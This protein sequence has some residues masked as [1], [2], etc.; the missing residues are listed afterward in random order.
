VQRSV[1][2]K[3]WWSFVQDL[4]AWGW[5]FAPLANDVSKEE[6]Q[7]WVNR[8]QWKW[9]ENRHSFFACLLFRF[10]G[11]FDAVE[12]PPNDPKVF[13]LWITMNVRPVLQVLALEF[14]ITSYPKEHWCQRGIPEPLMEWKLP[15]DKPALGLLCGG[16]TPVWFPAT[17][18]R[19]DPTEPGAFD[20]IEVIDN[21]LPV[22]LPN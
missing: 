18:S 6:I 11:K 12:I 9:R 10:C 15:C 3:L 5:S 21:M 22:Q 17:V 13:Q 14:A 16:T 8:F 2:A 20:T 4:T 19:P 1:I 7:D